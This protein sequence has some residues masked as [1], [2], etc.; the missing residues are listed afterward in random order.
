MRPVRLDPVGGKRSAQVHIG[1]R[2]RELDG[3]CY[4]GWSCA[5]VLAAHTGAERRMLMV[6]SV[7]RS[8]RSHPSIVGRRRST[9]FV[10]MVRCVL[11]D[12]GVIAS[13]SD[14]RPGHG[15]CRRDRQEGGQ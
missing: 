7:R 9:C 6:I 14:R 11:A 2:P 13:M 4:A 12:R 1:R 5:V 8:I 3:L 10:R 15:E